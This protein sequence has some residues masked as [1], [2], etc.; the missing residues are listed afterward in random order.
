MSAQDVVLPA[1]KDKLAAEGIVA[2]FR[3]GALVCAGTI[4]V[5]KD[6]GKILVDGPLCAEYYAVSRLVQSAFRLV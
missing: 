4:V 3:A 6:A 1:L 5:R 2:D